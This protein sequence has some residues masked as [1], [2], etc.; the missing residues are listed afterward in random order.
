MN[1]MLIPPSA[2]P[3]EFVLA[4]IVVTA[5]VID[6]RTSRI[7]NWLTA[8]GMLAGMLLS[9]LPQG[10]GFVHAVLGAGS[11]LALLIPLWLL[12]T[13]GAGDVKLL[14]MVGAFV[15]VPGIFFVLLFTMLA[16]G[17]FAVA[18]AVVRGHVLQM[19]LN[20]RELLQHTALAAVHRYR[21]GNGGIASVGQLPYGV[22]ICVG[23]SAWLAW[24]VL[25][26]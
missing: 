19:A 6:W 20:V 4:A 3:G 1:A 18:L 17:I 25:Q 2:T 12:R 11:A 23:T 26:R 8:G 13:T 16:G 15:G 14:V 9:L 24:Q 10:V 21:P 5:A 22:C 7:P